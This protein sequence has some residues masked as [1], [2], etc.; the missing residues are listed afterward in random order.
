MHSRLANTN[1]QNNPS[2]RVSGEAGYMLLAVVVMV[3]IVLITLAAAAP[4]IARDLRRDKEVESE[5]RAQQYVRAIR[6]YQRK[7]AG[8]YPPSIEVLE[9]SNNIRFLR[10]QYVD[11]LTGE[12]NWRLIRQGQQ[13]TSI[14]IPFGQELAGIATTG[15]G[16]AAG[17]SSSIGGSLGTAGTPGTASTTIGSTGG[18]AAGFAG[19]Q[20][21]GSSGTSGSS[22]IQSTDA[23]KLG[24]GGPIVGVATARSGD[25][26]LTP[27]GQTTYD[28]WEFWYDP[29]IEMLYKRSQILGGGGM[30]SG[31]S[32]T[33][34]G[35]GSTD[36]GSFGTDING[37]SNSGSGSS[38]SSSASSGTSTT[39]PK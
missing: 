35:I 32:G 17:L 6:L 37:R 33:G 28:S 14:K 25:S 19:A 13:Q 30:G 29:R 27:S 23:T 15:L 9:K 18:L 21:G 4:V 31:S 16:S 24:G 8:Q 11:P 5:M 38:G 10:K 34:T 36:A 1:A 39:T 3:A 22:G 7:F 12:A 26:I 2:Q 20:I